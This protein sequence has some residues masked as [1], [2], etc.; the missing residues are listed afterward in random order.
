MHGLLFKDKHC[1]AKDPLKF[2]N[3]IN[4]CLINLNLVLYN[5]LLL[6]IYKYLKYDQHQY[7]HNQLKNHRHIHIIQS[8]HII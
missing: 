2:N 7:Y 8:F 6:G 3:A 5:S 1:V 4:I